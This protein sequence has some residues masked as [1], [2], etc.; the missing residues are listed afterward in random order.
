MACPWWPGRGG[1]N[2]W[3][4]HHRRPSGVFGSHVS[5]KAPRWAANPVTGH[6]VCF[7]LNTKCSLITWAISAFSLKNMV[8]SSRRML[9]FTHLTE[10]VHVPVECFALDK[11]QAYFRFRELSPMPL[12]KWSNQQQP[13]RLNFCAFSWLTC[14]WKGSRII[15]R[16]VEALARS[17]LRRHAFKQYFRAC[18]Y[19]HLQF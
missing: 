8:K 15:E 2:V 11:L 5:V 6:L 1:D 7:W 13:E 3:S 17:C 12:Q 9:Y 14:F 10:T 19:S 16:A 4:N 18:L